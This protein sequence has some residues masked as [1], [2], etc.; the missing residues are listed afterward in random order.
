MAFP[1][2]L[3]PWIELRFVKL[4]ADTGQVVPNALGTVETFLA[5]TSTPQVTYTDQN[6]TANPT[7]IT[8]DSD[9]RPPNPIFLGPV[10]YKFTVSDSDAN[11]LYTLDDVEDIGLTFASNIGTLQTV[12]VTNEAPGYI[13]DPADRLVTIDTTGSATEPARITLPAAS[14]YT[15][16]LAIKNVGPIGLAIDPN[17]S[18]AIDIDTGGAAILLPPAS[19]NVL[20]GAVAVQPVV[21]LI[22]DNI[23]TWYVWSYSATG[24]DAGAT[25]VA[26]LPATKGAGFI[27]GVTDALTPVIGDPVTGGGAIPAL[28]WWTGTSWNVFAIQ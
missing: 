23:S 18:D 10:G 22:S 27:R 24:V 17:G 5:G 6:G 28:V 13:V 8:L 7:T 11:V 2:G 3:L 19:N 12:G 1:Y 9:G 14:S 4:D 15:G 25:T 16:I 26:L 20:S 21:I